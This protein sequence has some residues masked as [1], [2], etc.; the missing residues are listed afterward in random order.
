M[1]LHLWFERVN[2]DFIIKLPWLILSGLALCDQSVTFNTA[3]SRVISN[4]NKLARQEVIAKP[5]LVLGQK[6]IRIM[7][8]I[9][10]PVGCAWR[11]AFDNK[12]RAAVL[13]VLIP[14]QVLLAVF[15]Q[16]PTGYRNVIEIL[17]SEEF[18]DMIDYL[19][20]EF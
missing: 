4:Y 9:K 17:W 2:N 5:D 3:S 18:N 15:T 14:I 7:S 6:P 19:G 8:N 1:K 10:F 13:N 20:R 12:A 16:A 11:G